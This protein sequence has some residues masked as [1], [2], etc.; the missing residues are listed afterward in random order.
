MDTR[1]A[2]SLLAV[3]AETNALGHQPRLK[4][5]GILDHEFGKELRGLN[6]SAGSFCAWYKTTTVSVPKTAF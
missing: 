2:E 6:E 5:L 4:A 3:R 1:G